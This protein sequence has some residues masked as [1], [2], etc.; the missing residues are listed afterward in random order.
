M[1]LKKS[2]GIFACIILTALPQAKGLEVKKEIAMNDQK[3]LQIQD[4]DRLNYYSPRQIQELAEV[5]KS[6]AKVIEKKSTV[7]KESSILGELKYTSPKDPRKPINRAGFS[8]KKFDG[9]GGFYKISPN[10]EWHEGRYLFIE[11]QRPYQ[12]GLTKAFFSN[13]LGLVLEKSFFEKREHA[14]LSEY[15]VYHFRPKDENKEIKFI[16]ESRTDASNLHDG[17]PKS[18]HR[19]IIVDTV[20]QKSLEPK[21]PAPLPITRKSGEPC[22]QTGF[23]KASSTD[24]KYWNIEGLQRTAPMFVKLG[25]PMPRMTTSWDKAPEEKERSIVWTWVKSG[26]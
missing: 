16:F 4:Q 9:V 19:V 13:E 15:H 24:T 3:A 11:Q 20:V 7:E 17:Y 1:T 8:T 25:E 22:P 23:W 6:I 2:L 10:S 26:N 18:F 5:I 21:P 12:L 14:P